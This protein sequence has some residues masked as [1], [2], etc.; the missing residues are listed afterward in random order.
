[1]KFSSNFQ[2]KSCKIAANTSAVTISAGEILKDI[3]AAADAKGLVIVGGQALD[4]GIGGYI[5]AGGHG[6]LSVLYGLAADQVLEATI[7]TPSGQILTINEKQNSEY[8]YAFR[9]GGPGFGVLIDVSVKTFPTPPITALKLEIKSDVAD[10]AF[11]DQ[12]AYLLTQYPYLSSHDISGYPYIYPVY[13]TSAT[14]TA[15]VYTASWLIH[16]G[17]SEGGMTEIFAPIIQHLRRAWPEINLK[18]STSKYPTFY[19]HYKA[20]GSASDAG[21]DQV[22]GSRLLSADVLSG[23]LDALTTAVKGFIGYSS[24]SGASPFLLGGK[25]VANAV[26]TGGSDSVLPAWR[27][28]LAH[29]GE[30]SF[31]VIGVM[32]MLTMVA[33]NTF[34][35]PLNAMAKAEAMAMMDEQIQFL[36]D[37]APESGAYI[38]EVC[39][40]VVG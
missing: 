32:E 31:L 22:L 39:I 11:F 19:A 14:T 6:Q 4:V 29:F 24:A 27:S 20:T 15:A 21:K 36:R 7:V 26:P 23:D 9:G 13:A 18:N 5:T 1:L 33:S 25:G 37:L 30:D 28:S 3:Y 38:N 8:F 12:M 17:T 10:D 2:P 16:D 40:L 35:Q 34:W